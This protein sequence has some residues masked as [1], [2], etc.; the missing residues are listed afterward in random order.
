MIKKIEIVNFKAYGKASF[1]FGEGVNF[2]YGANGSGKTSLMEAISVALFGWQWV[3]SWG[4]NKWSNYLRRGAAW[5]EVKLYLSHGGREIVVARRF[6]EKGGIP[7][8]TYLAVDGGV[9]ARGDSDVTATLVS[10]LGLGLDEYAHLLYIRQGE[11][12]RILQETRYIDRIFRLDEFDKVDEVVKEVHDEFR[13][14]R[15]R[16]GGRLEELEKRLPVLRSRLDGL[17][18]RLEEAEKRAA[19]L[20]EASAR[21]REVERLYLE[22]RER[23][24]SLAK[25][26]EALE[27]KLEEAAQLALSAEKDVEQLEAELE[28]IRKAAEELKS[29]PEVGDVEKEYFELRQAVATAERVP[30]EVRSYDPRSLEETRRR[31]EEASR[32]HGEVKTRLALLRDV[33]RL[34]QRAEGGRCPVCGS[35]LSRDAVQRHELEVLG[36]EKEEE[37][38]SKLIAQLKA[39]VG[40]LEELDRLYHSYKPHLALDLPSARRRLAELEAL[41]Q[42]KKE[43][44]KRRAYLS[45]QVAREAEVARR[46]EELKARKA[47]AERKI[48]EVNQR[49]GELEAELAA[50]AEALKKLEAE[51]AA[52]KTRH[53]EYLAA[54]SVAAELRRQIAE[55]EKELAA[56]AG[57]LE[58]AKSDAER[59]DKALA[60]AR[61]IRVVLGELKPLMRQTLLKAINEELN[62]VFLRLRHKEAFKSLQLVETDG[63]YVIR[64]NTPTGP[65]DHGLLSLGEQNLAALSLRVALA[66][67][68]LGQAPFMMFD[69][70][71]EHLDEEHRRKIVELVR[72]LTSIVPTIIVTSH[73]GEFEEVA[74]VVIQL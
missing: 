48:Q 45:A 28:A 26:R 68:L 67:A 30:P 22:L 43:V 9:V 71:T 54:R 32:R 25:E 41:Y 27:K 17:R 65:I 11:L 70:P 58:K 33:L 8:G 35:P 50:A 69:E 21:F 10:K 49:L 13:A 55:T 72:G 64:V 24:A 3:N 46:L 29:L 19:E 37:R 66:R 40:R 1:R 18:R 61:Q 74:D 2:I 56:L 23:H 47:E 63:R 36:L 59:L 60:A 15:E 39:E 51:Y 53:E 42:K 7:S 5:G 34:A 31:L 62:A 73:L 14:R 44:E 4:G 6:S 12:R 57:E 20:E 38:L 16:A 52:L